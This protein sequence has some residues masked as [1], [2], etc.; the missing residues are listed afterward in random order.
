MDHN[1][2]PPRK[3][4]PRPP[5]GEYHPPFRGAFRLTALTHNRIDVSRGLHK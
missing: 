4:P 2:N 1:P 3:S 5:R